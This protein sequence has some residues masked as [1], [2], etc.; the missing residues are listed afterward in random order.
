MLLKSTIFLFF[1]DIVHAQI[2]AQCQSRT[3]NVTSIQGTIPYPSVNLVKIDQWE[4]CYYN[5]IIPLGYAL[6]FQI[7]YTMDKGDV[8]TITNS[9]GVTVGFTNFTGVQKDVYW[10]TAGDST[11]RVT[12]FS[13]NLAFLISYQFYSLKSYFPL[14]RYSGDYFQVSQIPP[15]QYLI[16]Y[17]SK[18]ALTLAA[19]TAAE[20]LKNLDRYMLYIGTDVMQYPA[21]GTLADLINGTQFYDNGRMYYANWITIVNFYDDF[22]SDAYIIANDGPEITSSYQFFITPPNNFTSKVLFD[23]TDGG[24]AVT[25]ACPDCTNFYINQLVFDTMLTSPNGYI[26]F[27]GNTPSQIYMAKVINYNATSFN[28]NQLP[29]IIPTNKFTL[30]MYKSLFTIELYSGDEYSA[31]KQ[32]RVGR[33]GL[34]S[35]VSLW[36]TVWDSATFQYEIRDD[37]QLY[38]FNVNIDNMNFTGVNFLNLCIGSG[39]GYNNQVNLTYPPALNSSVTSIGNYL[40]TSANFTMRGY[41]T[42]YYE[43]TAASGTTT[44]PILSTMTSSTTKTLT[45]TTTITTTKANILTTTATTTTP[46]VTSAPATTFITPVP[47]TPPVTNSTTI[48]SSNTG[49]TLSTT[50]GLPI[51]QVSVQTTT[52]T[53]PLKVVLLNVLSF[54]L[55]AELFKNLL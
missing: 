36:E 23:V 12:S 53:A 40:T 27:Q 39:P 24:G 5:F 43:I 50:I 48:Y 54:V 20:S 7:S 4:S 2:G 3:V 9:L 10:C 45:S 17:G 34:I 47:F 32:P 14:M 37:S 30:L 44:Q 19:N 1:L 38:N 15:A 31:W 16:F 28:P 41:I 42:L 6:Q 11:L 26:A 25:F 21:S 55:I 35:S 18:L 52:Q 33:T 46:P 13:G 29:Q 8:L 51:T 49:S 22:K